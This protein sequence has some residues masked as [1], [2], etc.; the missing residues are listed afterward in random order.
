[1]REPE[2]GRRQ[3]AGLSWC[4]DSAPYSDLSHPVDYKLVQVMLKLLTYACQLRAN[5][6]HVLDM[7]EPDRQEQR[8]QHY[9]GS[10]RTARADAAAD[11]CRSAPSST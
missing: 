4:G 7:A 3:R 1:M 10:V 5:R 8:R 6:R 9:V 2:R 11:P